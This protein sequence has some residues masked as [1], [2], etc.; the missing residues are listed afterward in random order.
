MK[1]KPRI[2]IPEFNPEK[3]S[4][5][6]HILGRSLRNRRRNVKSDINVICLPGQ[7]AWD[8]H[9]F[10]GHDSIKNI[11]AIERISER[12]QNLREKF[13]DEPRVTVFEGWTTEFLEKTDMRFEIAYLDYYSTF[14]SLIRTDIDLLFRRRIVPPGGKI[15]VGFYA[16]RGPTFEHIR[17]YLDCEDLFK[18]AG[19][20]PPL[21]EDM[22]RAL[23]LTRAFN[24]FIARY[25]WVSPGNVL[26]RSK[27]QSFV[28]T[29]APSWYAYNGTPGNMLVAD[30]SIR[31]YGSERKWY[32]LNRECWL[33]T[34]RYEEPKRRTIKSLSGVWSRDL[35]PRG[36]KE[37]YWR[38]RIEKFYEEHHYTPSVRDLGCTCPPVKRWTGLIR[39]TGLCP[40]QGATIEEIKGEISR[41]HEREGYA[42]SKL[43]RTAKVLRKLQDQGYKLSKILKE[44]GIPNRPPGPTKKAIILQEWISHLKKEEP[45]CE[46]RHYSYVRKYGYL[47]LGKARSALRSLERKR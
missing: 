4:L 30:L 40:R 43:L 45:K 10:L 25:R 13:K 16:E 6:L 35:G 32:D 41:V 33:R 29:M 28:G 31:S 47:D 39:S 19:V 44:M 23:L 34:G 36:E 7:T 26:P 42:D 27:D 5:Q 21:K 15:I 2:A 8:V 14:S 20:E 3:R 11:V 46:F 12:A 22:S 37:S 17:Q 9:Y 38:A 24:G 1:S 18:M